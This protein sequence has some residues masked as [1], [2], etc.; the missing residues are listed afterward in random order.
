MKV[1]TKDGRIVE[2]EPLD[3]QKIFEMEEL[4]NILSACPVVFI[5]TRDRRALA[6]YLTTHLDIC[7]KPIASGEALPPFPEP[8]EYPEPAPKSLPLVE[9]PDDGP[10][11]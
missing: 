9:A 11:F 8:L 2:G 6:E 5:A 10:P 4:P 1:L 7:R 3:K